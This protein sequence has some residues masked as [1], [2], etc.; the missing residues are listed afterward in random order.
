MKLTEKHFIVGSSKNG[1]IFSFIIILALLT[2]FTACSENSAVNVETESS[3][4]SSKKIYL[5][6]EKHG[7]KKIMDK[8][9]ELWHE[10]YNNKNMRHLFV[11]LP[12]YT[13]EFLN[14]WMKSD[15][16]EILDE[17]YNDWIGT[18][19][20]N[21]YTKEFYKKIKSNCPETIFHG[22]DVGHQYDTTG[23]RFLKYLEENNLKDSEKYRL[24]HEAVK[25]GKYYYENS[26]DVYRENKMVENFIREYDALNGEC[27]MGIYG[28]A[29]TSL[30]AMDF[31]DSVPCM[32]NQ[33][34]DIYKDIIYS[35]DL[36]WL[37]MNP[38]ER[39]VYWLFEKK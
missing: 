39:I 4:K 25:Q 27:I 31:T 36:S 6:G 19:L 14:I 23:Q 26:D 24:A 1:Y 28:N 12:Y 20:Y 2:T 37:A 22:T 15:S 3:S 13:A 11:E 21:P 10:Y 8:E 7:V 9:F 30:D 29:H 33:L 5:Y 38:F 18:A 32:A 16:D 35:E 34:K 17:L